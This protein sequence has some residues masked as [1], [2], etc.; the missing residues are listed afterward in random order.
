MTEPSKL[1]RMTTRLQA[2]IPRLLTWDFATLVV[3]EKHPQLIRD[4]CN[5]YTLSWRQKLGPELIVDHAFNVLVPL[6]MTAPLAFL[7]ALQ[8]DT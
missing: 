7:P 2:P 5:M 3:A 8:R 4:L 6:K 1:G